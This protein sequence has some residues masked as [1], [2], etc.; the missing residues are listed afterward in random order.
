MSEAWRG[1]K[2]DPVKSVHSEVSADSAELAEAIKA[3]QTQLAD[4]RKIV[5][6]AKVPTD[7]NIEPTRR[8]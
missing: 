6:A 4:L 3:L 1:A 2:M 5:Q 8:Q 7:R